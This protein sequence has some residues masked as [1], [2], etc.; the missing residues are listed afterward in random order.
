MERSYIEMMELGSFEERLEYLRLG[1]GNVTSPRSIS[2]GFYHSPQWK[3]TRD[4]IIRRDGAFDLGV[5]GVIIPG[6]II[7]HHIN[8]I[9]REDLMSENWAKLINP[10]N[11]I[12]VSYDTHNKIHYD[13]K[14]K[15]PVVLERQQGDTIL[16]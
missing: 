15:P 7:V 4:E 9:T 16:W 10:D 2:N 6:D 14:E 1:D 5:F 12:S 13:R 8:P 3:A 11:L